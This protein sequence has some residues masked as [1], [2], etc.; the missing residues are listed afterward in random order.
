MMKKLGEEGVVCMIKAGCYIREKRG[1]CSASMG[2]DIKI[3]V[4]QG[5][6]HSFEA[7]EGIFKTTQQ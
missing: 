6:M 7:L 5:R 3:S 4:S 2:F 1:L